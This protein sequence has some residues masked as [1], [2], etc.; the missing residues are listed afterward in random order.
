MKHYVRVQDKSTA[1]RS[2]NI[3]KLGEKLAMDVLARNGFTNI[4]NLNDEQ[5]NH[6]YADIYAERSGER[7]VISVKACNKNQANGAL[8]GYYNLSSLGNHYE[9]AKVAENAR[10]A[11]AA[12]ATVAFDE[13]TFNA[14]FGLLSALDGKNTIPMTPNAVKKHECLAESEPHNLDYST[15]KNDYKNVDGAGVNS[16]MVSESRR[17]TVDQTHENSQ[18]ELNKPNEYTGPFV[19]LKSLLLEFYDTLDKQSESRS[20]VY[21]VSTGLDDLDAITGGLQ[22][23]NLVLV[24]GGAGMGKSTLCQNIARL[25]SKREDTTVALFNLEATNKQVVQRLLAADAGVDTMR[26]LTGVLSE[27]ELGKFALCVQRLYNA[28]LLMDDKLHKSV[29]DIWAACDELLKVGELG[30]VIIDALPLVSDG[31]PTDVWNAAKLLKLMARQFNV[32][33]VVA[34]HLYS[35]R[36]D[37]RAERR[38]VMGDLAGVESYADEVILLHRTRLPNL[39]EDFEDPDGIELLDVIVAKQANGPTGL[40][41][42]GFAPQFALITNLD[43]EMRDEAT[44]F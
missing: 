34:T 39:R 31:A 42:L 4:K 18:E 3:G 38:P 28:P 35:G 11:K 25:V 8:N 27:D 10:Q 16:T 24:A 43:A 40:I 15:I 30:L 9:L 36:T 5:A 1:M 37:R 29:T 22:K 20:H 33:V 41:K 17:G 19:T 26:F 6:G 7:Y 13:N 2:H 21:G 23:G 14:Y 32:P 12:W 44:G